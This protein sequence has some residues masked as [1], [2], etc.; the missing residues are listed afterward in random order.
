ME[1]KKFKEQIEK[2][3]EKMFEERRQCWIQLLQTGIISY[4]PGHFY[5]DETS[6]FKKQQLKQ[7]EEE[8]STE[9]D[10]IF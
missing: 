5:V 9:D 10:F 6:E 2:L 7:I 8:E 1:L 3:N 4:I